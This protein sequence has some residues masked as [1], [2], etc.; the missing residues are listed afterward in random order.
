MIP[1]YPIPLYLYTFVPYTILPRSG[2]IPPD[3]GIEFVGAHPRYCL[4][5][6]GTVDRDFGVGIGQPSDKT[7]YLTAR[8]RIRCEVGIPAPPEVGKRLWTVQERGD[9]IFGVDL[10]QRSIIGMIVN[11]GIHVCGI[12][13]RSLVNDPQLFHVRTNTRGGGYSFKTIIFF[14]NRVCAPAIRRI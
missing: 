13:R 12:Y 3:P 9:P 5:N 11:V 6:I 4:P 1:L 7:I 10:L 14:S 2:D 8:I